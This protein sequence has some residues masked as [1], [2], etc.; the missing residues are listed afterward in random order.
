MR[1]FDHPLLAAALLAEAPRPRPRGEVVDG[2]VGRRE[3]RQR[4]VGQQ[5]DPRRVDLAPQ[6]GHQLAP[7]GTPTRR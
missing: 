4:A 1:W 7:E 6:R 3:L 5:V 2:V